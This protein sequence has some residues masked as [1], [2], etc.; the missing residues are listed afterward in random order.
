MTRFVIRRLLL[1]VPTFL[2]VAVLVFVLVRV[3]PGDIVELRLV[4]GGTFVTPGVVEAERARLG[5]NKPLWRQFADWMA[6]LARGDLGVSMWSGQPIT[7]EISLRLQLSLELAV[8]ATV[9]AVALALPLGTAA[10]VRR[11][12]W[13]DH[14]VQVFSVA[15]LATPSFWLGILLLLFLLT[16]FRWLPPLTFTPLWKDPRANL[17]QLLWPALAVGYRY[18]AVATRMTRS[19][20]LE[21][22]RE[23]YVRTAWAKGLTREDIVRRH[24]LRNAL[25]PVVAVVGLEFAFLIGGLVVTEQVFNL[26]GIGKL[27]VDAVAHRDYTL[28]QGLMLVVAAGYILVTFLLDLV[29]AWIDPRVSYD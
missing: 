17:L 1:T 8:L 9:I 25:L 14:A 24:A 22:L 16:Y 12:T 21:V 18:S 5:L 10:A 27:F 2:A 6:G 23:D 13:V 11:G 4:S 20:L 15:G 19:A 3:V 26:N 7:R 29:Y 28:I